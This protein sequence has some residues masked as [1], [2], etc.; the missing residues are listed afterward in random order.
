MNKIH[1]YTILID[2]HWKLKSWIKEKTTLTW[3]IGDLQTR[4]NSWSADSLR[5]RAFASSMLNIDADD[6]MPK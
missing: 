5:K 3:Y 1:K 4:T 6:L 2:N